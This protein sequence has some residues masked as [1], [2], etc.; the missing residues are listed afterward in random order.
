MKY[1]VQEKHDDGIYFAFFFPFFT[2][3]HMQCIGKFV[4][5]ISQELLHLGILKFG[6]NIST[7]DTTSCI[8]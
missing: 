8:V 6:T 4:S 7:L 2:P 1:T 5:K 3:M